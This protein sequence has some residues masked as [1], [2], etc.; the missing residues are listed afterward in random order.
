M[1]PFLFMACAPKKGV[2]AFINGKHKIE[3]PCPEEGECKLE[4]LKDKSLDIKVDDTG[5]LYYSITD[6]PGKV[7]VRYTY[8]YDAPKGVMDA[9]YTET[10]IFETDDEFSNL[11]TGNIKGI[12]MLFG[13][14]CFCRGKAGFYTVNEGKISYKDEKLTVKIP[15]TIVD[16]QRIYSI[17]ASLK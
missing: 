12:K 8:D 1:L 17:D 5:R 4:I 14:Q 3:S 15:D 7:I 6:A 9:G 2:T 16:G 10:V 13:V 11:N